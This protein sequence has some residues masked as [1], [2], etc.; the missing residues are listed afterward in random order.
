MEADEKVQNSPERIIQNA[1]IGDVLDDSFDENDPF[2]SEMI[3]AASTVA[4]SSRNT[5]FGATGEAVLNSSFLS[6]SQIKRK[7][8]SC[9]SMELH[10]ES[11]Q[12][13]RIRNVSPVEELFSDS[14]NS[15]DVCITMDNYQNVANVDNEENSLHCKTLSGFKSA[16]GKDCFVSLKALEKAE[17]FFET[18]EITMVGEVPSGCNETSD[19]PST[20]ESCTVPAVVN[21]SVVKSAETENEIC[22]FSTAAG[23]RCTVNSASIAKAQELFNSTLAEISS[24]PSV[25][26]TALKDAVE[27]DDD[28]LNSVKCIS[29]ASEIVQENSE[30][31]RSLSGFVG[32]STASGKKCSYS[33]EALEKARKLLNSVD[34]DESIPFSKNVSHTSFVESTSSTDRML[35]SS[36]PSVDTNSGKMIKISGMAVPRAEQSF[37]K[38]VAGDNKYIPIQSASLM[39]KFKPNCNN[40]KK[41]KL[42]DVCQTPSP[43]GLSSRWR[44]GRSSTVMRGTPCTRPYVQIFPRGKLNRR[45]LYRTVQ[46]ESENLEAK[47][48]DVADELDSDFLTISSTKLNQNTTQPARTVDA[49][50]GKL[51]KLWKSKIS[52]YSK[53]CPKAKPQSYLSEGEIILIFM[54]KL[55]AMGVREPTLR[56]TRKTA[57]EFYF[58]AD[59]VNSEPNSEIIV[60]DDVIVKVDHQGGIS[61]DE[62]IR[63]FCRSSDVD[64]KLLNDDWIRNHLQWIVFKLASLE[65]QFPACLAARCL[66]VDNVLLQLRYRYDR[67]LEHAQRPLLRKVL[68]RDY[69]ATAPM[70]LRVVE[71]ENMDEEFAFFQCITVELTDGWYGINAKLDVC[72]SDLAKRGRIQVGMKL[73][74]IN[75]TLHGA[76]GGC[77]PLEAPCNVRL[78]LTINGVRRARWWARL[79]YLRVT[80]TPA[81]PISSL[82]EGKVV[83]V[84]VILCRKYPPV[85]LEKYADGRSVMRNERCEEQ[86]SLRFAEEVDHLMETM[87]E[88]VV[89]D[90]CEFDVDSKGGGSFLS[91]T[92][93]ME[94]IYNEDDAEQLL[95]LYNKCPDPER[96]QNMI[97]SS[98]LNSILK[99]KNRLDEKRAEK[100]REMLERDMATLKARQQ[101]RTVVPILK[102]RISDF[103]ALNHGKSY[104]LNIWRP[105]VDELNA[106]LREG[107]AYSFYQ[108]QAALS[109]NASG[110]IELNSE[111][112]TRIVELNIRSGCEQNLI[113][114]KFQHR[115]VTLLGDLQRSDFQA[116]YD[117]VD[118]VGFVID[119]ASATDV[120]T[121]YLGDQAMNIVALKIPGGLQSFGWEKVL[122]V[123]NFI[124]CQNLHYIR[125]SKAR[126]PQLCATIVTLIKENPK[127]LNLNCSLKTL[128]EE[129]LKRPEFLNE[130][131]SAFK[132]LLRGSSTRTSLNTSAL[133]IHLHSNP[134]VNQQFKSP[135]ISK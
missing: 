133:S 111:K 89:N 10:S 55:L 45:F 87:L 56:V 12:S 92:S 123:G 8:P 117:E 131:R 39:S 80:K 16:S 64:N 107:N 99:Y 62:I 95:H 6:A 74:I 122:I 94:E 42:F 78:A 105:D 34:T 36:S 67:E 21:W 102:L 132:A 38:S 63:G 85:Y 90:A 69:P 49:G 44:A 86:I 109:R 126:I 118:I 129:V 51:F 113:E 35:L 20:E 18:Q 135:Q 22:G 5:E 60:A 106:R 9:K 24:G 11:S 43:S 50:G 125:L 121:V 59:Y 75:A 53:F 115:T 66:N 26:S 40:E 124:A 116:A 52:N 65:I 82:R 100:L 37:A 13:K 2:I 127:E 130:A 28:Q 103:N 110:E 91:T 83:A 71:F 33:S 68:N 93:S 119:I 31:E 112:S 104:I 77:E 72:L 97:T 4:T 128:K 32:F 84:K 76:E 27:N 101:L 54:A 134:S 7:L 81:F 79:G 48:T 19:F 30:T 61:M 88:R 58:T 17:H 108:L 41:I 114:E 70:I 47:H 14:K 25:S 1:K 98:Q 15:G 29:N 57:S 73:F 46:S 120:D 96:F 23:K 3:K